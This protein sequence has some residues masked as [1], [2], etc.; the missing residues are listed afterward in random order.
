[1]GKSPIHAAAARITG[2]LAR[3]EIPFAVAGALAANAHGH[4]RTTED[5]DIL[6]TA[7]GLARFKQEWLGRGWV[8]QFE[9]SRGLRDMTHGVRI[10]VLIAGEFPGD[11]KPK[12]VCFPDPAA[13][14]ELDADGVPILTLRALITLKLASGQSAPHRLRDLDDVMQLIRANGLPLDYGDQ[15][16]PYVRGKFEEMWRA[17]QVRDES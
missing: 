6:L 17:A 4:V 7:D 9:G 10:D 3:M 12:P 1:M 15:L 8:E 2:A 16:D 11:G 14:S 5:V 13:A